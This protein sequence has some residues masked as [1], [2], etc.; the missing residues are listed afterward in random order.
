FVLTVI[1]LPQGLVPAIAQGLFVL[2]RPVRRALDRRPAV[3]AT[4]RQAQARAAAVTRG[5]SSAVGGLKQGNGMA[6]MADKAPVLEFMADKAP[7]LELRNVGM[8]YGSLVALQGVNLTA[9]RGEVVGI[10]GPNGAGK[11]T[12]L[13]CIADGRERST[14]EVVINGHRIA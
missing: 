5:R 12:L 2:A 10:V 6:G 14:G 4:H 7:V 1:Y 13:R 11:T 9:Y 8:Q 3:T